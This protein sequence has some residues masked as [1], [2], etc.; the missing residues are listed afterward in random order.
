MPESRVSTRIQPW[1]QAMEQGVGALRGLLD[2]KPPLANLPFVVD[3]VVVNGISKSESERDTE[4]TDSDSD[5]GPRL[6]LRPR[7]TSTTSGSVADSDSEA[8]S[9][10]LSAAARALYVSLLPSQEVSGWRFRYCGFT[11]ICEKE[12]NL[13]H[14][15][16]NF[17]TN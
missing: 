16:L 7:S 4:H 13:K 3:A 14:R 12:G 2:S 9:V 10:S 1:L 17:P 5:Q 15:F 11:S 6:V 8:L